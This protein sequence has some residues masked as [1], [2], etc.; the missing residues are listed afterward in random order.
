MGLSVGI[1]LA[2]W[3]VMVAA[4]A[5]AYWFEDNVHYQFEECGIGVNDADAL[6]MPGAFAFSLET[7][8]TVG[9]TYLQ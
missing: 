5:W 1:L 8:T 3:V 4:F 6:S 7:W 2:I 9:C